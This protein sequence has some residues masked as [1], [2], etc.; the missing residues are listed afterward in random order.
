MKKSLAVAVILLFIGVAFAPSIHADS[1]SETMEIIDRGYFR[2]LFFKPRDNNKGWLA[3][4]L[5]VVYNL[6]SNP[7]RDVYWFKWLENINID[8]W[9]PRWGRLYEVGFGR[10]IWLFGPCEVD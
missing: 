7:Q 10:F 9:N 1:K 2:G 4:H 3:I 8:I 5:V 6:S